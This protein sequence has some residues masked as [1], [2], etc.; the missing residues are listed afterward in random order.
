M[1]DKVIDVTKTIPTNTTPTKTI[2]TKTAATKTTPTQTIPCKI[3]NFYFTR[4]FMNY[5][6]TMDN[7]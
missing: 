3:K 4:L 6:V 7:Y 1:R 2:P 5:P